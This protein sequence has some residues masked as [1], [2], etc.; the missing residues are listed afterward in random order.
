M[1]TDDRPAMAGRAASGDLPNGWPLRRWATTTA[2]PTATTPHKIDLDQWPPANVT[3]CHS[4]G[5]VATP[6]ANAAPH[7]AA[8]SQP[9][10]RKNDN[11]SAP[12]KNSISSAVTNNRPSRRGIAAAAAASPH[13][14]V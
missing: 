2:Q 14:S 10:G 11:H 1:I 6:S 5:H 13:V 12:G 9:R 4:T 3:H 7:H 8:P